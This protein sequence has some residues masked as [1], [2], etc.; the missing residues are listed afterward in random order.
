MICNAD[1]GKDVLPLALDLVERL[2]RPTVNHPRLIMNTDR[3][4][5]A[6]RLANIPYCKVPKTIKVAGPVLAQ[7]ALN[8]EFAGFQLPLL[9]RIA[10]THGGDDFDKIDSWADIPGF[11][12]KKPAA[13][14]YVIEYIDYRSDDGFHRKYRVIF[15]DGEILPYHLAIHDD[16][17][18][19]HF[20]TDMANQPWMR[21]EE[22]QF[23]SDTGSVFNA[24]QQ[25]ALQAIATA[26]GLDYGGIDCGQ[27][28]DGRVIV[29]EANAAMLVHDEKSEDFAYKNQ[30]IAKIKDAFGTMLARRRIHN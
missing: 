2:G 22:E 13:D 3:E 11:I 16:W 7:A 6:R 30:Y 18:V 29:F 4:S 14:Y 21:R 17:K 19:H 1:D 9:A 12:S 27:G 28:R 5:V 8:K 26:T 10:G 15:V 20:R 23:L 25:E 24:A